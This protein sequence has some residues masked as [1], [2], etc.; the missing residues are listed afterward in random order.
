M[1][2]SVALFLLCLSFSPVRAD[3]LA[4]KIGEI[5]NGPD[6]KQAHWGMLIVDAKTGKTIYEL[7]PDRLFT[8]ASTT[9]LFSCA[10]AL[11]VLG[12]DFR[13]ETPIYKRGEMKEGILTGDLIL[14]ASGDLTLGGRAGK[15]GK[16]LFCNS[17]HTYANSGLGTPELPDADPLAGL[18]ELAAK[19][20]EHGLKELRGELM[21]DDRLFTRARSSGS[22]PEVVSPVLV[23]DNVIDVMI[24]PGA[25]AG[26]PAKVVIRPD[27]SAVSMDAEVTTSEKGKAASI[28]ITPVAVNQFSVRGSIPVG[29]KPIVRIYPIDEPTLFL[30]TLL[31][32]CM[33]K[34]GIK[35]SCTLSRP[36]FVD[37]PPKDGYTNLEKIASF[38]SAPLHEMIAVT[39]KVSHNLY[40]STLPCLVGVRDGKHDL[41]GGLRSQAQFLKSLGIPTETISFA[42]GAGGANAD[43]I[44]PRAAIKLLEAMDKRQEGKVFFEGLPNLGIDGTLADVVPAS[45]PAKGKA[46]AKTGTLIWF[47][48]LNGRFLLQS[49]ALAGQIETKQGTR[50]FFAMFVN[51]VPLPKGVNSSREGKILGKLCEI[52]HEHGP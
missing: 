21:I 35:F 52:I 33:R 11:G 22:G 25:K 42:G 4:D 5:I 16:T 6:Y 47:D 31:L 38:K 17:D 51:D 18:K 36:Q 37:L 20:K 49:K 32:E 40:A 8:P 13:F 2:C 48:A 45:S 44:T 9:K 26:D 23:N 28:T 10:T 27:T 12:P 14:V 15:N 43:K 46:Q 7:N 1:R 41:E 19:L 30:R 34:E 3:E 50:L 29:A 24:T 39:L